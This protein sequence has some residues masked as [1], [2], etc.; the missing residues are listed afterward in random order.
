MGIIN[1]VVAPIFV[2]RHLLT[3]FG[4]TWGHM[5]VKKVKIAHLAR[6]THKNRKFAQASISSW[7]LWCYHLFIT[8]YI[9][10][11]IFGELEIKLESKRSKNNSQMQDICTWRYFIKENLMESL[12]FDKIL[13]ST[14][15]GSPQIYWGIKMPPCLTEPVY[16]RPCKSKNVMMLVHCNIRYHMSFEQNIYSVGLFIYNLK[17]RL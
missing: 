4:V 12:S 6:K 16:K 13:Y 9:S 3:I 10:W 1:P 15:L 8:Y 7:E 11:D 2:K 14:I 17:S 5:G